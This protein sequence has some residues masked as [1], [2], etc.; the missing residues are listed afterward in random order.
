MLTQSNRIIIPIG[1]CLINSEIIFGSIEAFL[2]CNI[3]SVFKNK[4]DRLFGNMNVNSERLGLCAR[5]SDTTLDRNDCI[6]QI[7]KIRV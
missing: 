6:L 7:Y 2:V 5:T 4:P 3:I 1:K